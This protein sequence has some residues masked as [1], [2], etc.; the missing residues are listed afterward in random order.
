MTPNRIAGLATMHEFIGVPV[1][2]LDHD[3]IMS[4]ILPGHP[5]HEGYQYLSCVHK[6]DY[7]RSYFMHFYGGGYGDIKFF[8]DGGNWIKCFDAMDADE[9]IWA[10]GVREIIRG[11]PIKDYKNY[12]DIKQLLGCGWFICRPQTPFTEKWYAAVQK[13]MDE[14]L[15]V[16]KKHPADPRNPRHGG[17]GYPVRWSELHGAIFHRII[18]DVPERHKRNILQTGVDWSRDYQ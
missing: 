6:S 1:E 7:L 11:T 15:P 5:L 8:K 4:R 2:L 12:V 14:L 16:L 10:I 9:D 18:H 17:A 3:G 13:K